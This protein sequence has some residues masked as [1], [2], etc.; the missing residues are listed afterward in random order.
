MCIYFNLLQLE[1]VYL[2]IVLRDH[3]IHLLQ[4]LVW[5]DLLL[6]ELDQII[7]RD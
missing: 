1:Q 5:L 3:L 7:C 4:Q 2:G 6:L